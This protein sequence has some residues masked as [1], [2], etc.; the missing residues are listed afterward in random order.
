MCNQIEDEEE[1][2]CERNKLMKELGREVQNKINAIWFE[3]L[4]NFVRVCI[5]PMLI[6]NKLSLSL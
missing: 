2:T 5:W 3:G 6:E 4:P 1:C